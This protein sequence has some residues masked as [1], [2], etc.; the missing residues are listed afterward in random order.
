LKKRAGGTLFL[1]EIADLSVE[2]QVKLLRLLDSGEFFRVGGKYAA[3]GRFATG[4]GNEQ[5]P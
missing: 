2:T 3:K 4:S 5:R 1:D